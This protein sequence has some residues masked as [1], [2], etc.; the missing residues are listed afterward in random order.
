[1]LKIL[2]I[3]SLGAGLLSA[4]QAEAAK[5]RIG[6]GKR[7]ADERS[8][9]TGPVLVPGV[10]GAR[11]TAPAA[12]EAARVP[13]PPATAMPAFVSLDTREPNRPWCRS[14]VVVGGF[15]VLN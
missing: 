1:M 15:C 6:G 10:R 13:F 8:S 9:T 12:G 5:L 14:K 3:A 7:A 11:N 4:S 2:L